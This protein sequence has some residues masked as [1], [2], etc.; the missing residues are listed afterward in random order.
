MINNPRWN[1]VQTTARLPLLGMRLPFTGRARHSVRA[2]FGIHRSF[3]CSV[4]HIPRRELS[5]HSQMHRRAAMMSAA[6]LTPIEIRWLPTC[7][8][9]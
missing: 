7:T 6:Q 8:G 2:A 3:S 1:G 5:R 9:I 4:P